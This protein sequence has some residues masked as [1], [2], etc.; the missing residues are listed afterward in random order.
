MRSLLVRGK[1]KR[2]ITDRSGFVD[3]LQ[4]L[5]LSVKPVDVET[6]FKKAPEF[7]MSFS[8][9]HQ[10]MGA[11]GDL[12]RFKLT[13]NPLIPRRVDYVVGDDLSSTEQAVRLFD[14]KF[15]VYYLANILSS[16]VLG[17]ER[18]GKM[19]PTRW[20]ITAVD[21][22]LGKELI[23]RLRNFPDVK[24]I[25]VYENTYLDNHFE[26][27]LIPGGWNFELFEAWSPNTL[28][29]KGESQHNVVV[30]HELHKGRKDYAYNEGGGYYAGRFAVAEGLYNMRRQARCVVFREIYESYV[31][32]VGVWEVREN[33]RYAMNKPPK[34]FNTVN[35]ALEDIGTRLTLP[36]N[37]YL[38]KST[39]LRQRRITDYT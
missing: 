32:P 3:K 1:Q 4:E 11:V 13:E 30:E 37:R 6:H 21:D 26:I 25:M 31:V 24:D 35:E 39:I 5:A 20:S 18:R 22:V 17:S 10:P 38:A 23:G 34:R 36:I 33:V 12:K 2:P 8:P 7:T 27:L 16:G 29:T 15:D 9:V 28:W 14:S 19:V